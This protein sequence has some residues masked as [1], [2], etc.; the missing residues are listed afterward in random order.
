MI[1]G[2]PVNT[3]LNNSYANKTCLSTYN[4]CI[5]DKMYYLMKHENKKNREIKDPKKDSLVFCSKHTIL[6]VRF[7]RA[8]NGVMNIV[9]LKSPLC[10][11]AYLSLVF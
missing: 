2:K 1:G 4:K 10:I 5:I 6:F 7:P 3:V 8:D 11:L 9:A